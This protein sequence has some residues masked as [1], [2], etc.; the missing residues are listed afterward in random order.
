MGPA[1]FW[2]AALALLIYDH[3]QDRVSSPVFW[4]TLMLIG[5]VFVWLVLSNRARAALIEEQRRD[6]QTDKVT[7]LLNRLKLE[8]DVA[9]VLSRPHGRQLLV[10]VELD[11]LHAQH[12]R[13]GYAGADAVLRRVA[14]RLSH[15]VA[16]LGGRAYRADGNQFALLVPAR[17]Q[18]PGEIVIAAT[19]SLV[20]DDD[21]LLIEPAHGAVALPDDASDPGLAFKLA[22]HRLATRRQRQHR[23]ASWQ[24]HAALLAVQSARRPELRRDLRDLAYRVLAVGRRLG[25]EDDHLDDIVR[26][27]QLQDIGLLA[28]PEAILEKKTALTEEEWAVIRS[29]PVVGGQ[30]LSA[31]PALGHVAE[32]V[33]TSCEHFDGSGYPD[34]L[35]DEE[36][37]LGARIIAV[38]VAFAA[39]TSPRPYRA[40]PLGLWEAV[41]ELRRNAGTQFDPAV[42]DALTQELA[43]TD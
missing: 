16:P 14:Q 5:S 11:D 43:S 7:G 28:V 1:L 9:G 36:I 41:E 3:V 18:E 35:T 32:L 42:V 17:G 31:A 38:C 20:E 6:A 26:A 25:V 37:P 29:H 8:T 24:A 30:I 12:E 21:D 39:M 34:G 40:T 10:L 13:L 4:G 2:I 27:A 19:S 15:A 33:R 22:N 23:S